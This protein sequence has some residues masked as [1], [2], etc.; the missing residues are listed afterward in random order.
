MAARKKAD[1]LISD[2]EE[3]KSRS[4]KKRD[5]SAMQKKGEE[6]AALSPA[7]QG[8]LP[9]SP[10]LEEALA[11]WRGLKTWEAKRRHMQYI[12]R[13]MREL[14]EPEAFL[15]ALDE[16]QEPARGEARAFHHVE[17]LRDELLRDNAETRAKV[18][19]AALVRHP[20]L[21]RARLAH[22]V[23]AALAEREKQRPPKQGRALFRYLRE[24][25]ES[26]L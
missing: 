24:N 5:S 2:E 16:I 6:L 9:L 3:Y 13:L 8:K 1:D 10:E 17:D 11:H 18:M 20:S 23:E 21:E 15:E 25:M 4:Q 12:G 22:L 26:S 19:E 14:D 7:L